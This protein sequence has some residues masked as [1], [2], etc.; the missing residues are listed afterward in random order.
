VL[1][2]LSGILIVVSCIL[3]R[4]DSLEDIREGKDESDLN[5][6]KRTRVKHGVLSMNTLLVKVLGSMKDGTSCKKTS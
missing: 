1:L 2:F 5:S 4:V 3:E 6:G